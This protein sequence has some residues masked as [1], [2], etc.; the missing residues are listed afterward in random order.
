MIAQVLYRV[1]GLVYF[2]DRIYVCIVVYVFFQYWILDVS[3][4]G[5]AIK[6]LSRVRPV[7]IRL[8]AV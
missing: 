8:E 6:T 2:V 5:H 7:I 3:K 1:Q 4:I